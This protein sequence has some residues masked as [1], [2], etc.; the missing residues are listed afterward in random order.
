MI[1]LYMAFFTFFALSFVGLT[2]AQ[3]LDSIDV[4]VLQYENNQAILEIYWN[5]YEN[6]L[7]YEIGCV[8]CMPNFSHYVDA[9]HITISDVTPLPNTHNAMLYVIALDS[10]DEIIAAKQIIVNLEN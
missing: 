7:N 6:I 4:T 9:N 8:S 3:P 1:Y 5:S 2:Y 10:D